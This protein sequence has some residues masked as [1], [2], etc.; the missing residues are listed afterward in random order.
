MV[1]L[2][3]IS[4]AKGFLDISSSPTINSISPP[5]LMLCAM[6]FAKQWNIKILA[7]FPPSFQKYI[8]YRAGLQV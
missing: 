6:E 8:Y 7:K 3:S 1:I 2:C 5:S 4:D